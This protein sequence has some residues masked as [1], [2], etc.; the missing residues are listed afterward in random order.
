MLFRSHKPIEECT[1]NKEP[2]YS[3]EEISEYVELQS[4]YSSLESE[5]ATLMNNYNDLLANF[6]ALEGNFNTIKADNERL[7]SEIAPLAQFKKDFDKK[8]KKAMIDSFYMLSEEDKQDVLENIDNYS[9]EDIEAKLSV[10]CVRKKVSFSIEP[11]TKP[12]SYSFNTSSETDDSATPAWVKA[13]L[14]VAKTLNN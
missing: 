12:V 9:L 14:R 5:H 11:E 8:E 13:A 10:M 3:L 6:S 1:C 2:K 7:V 4:K